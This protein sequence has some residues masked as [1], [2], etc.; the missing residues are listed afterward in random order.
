MLMVM[1]SILMT[2]RYAVVFLALELPPDEVDVNVHPTKCEVRFRDSHALHQL[3]TAELIFRRGTPPDAEYTF[4]HAL[5]QDAAYS[6]LLR[7]R[8]QQLHALITAT[9]EDRFPE[10]VASQ[11][12]LL[13]KHCAEAGLN[14]KAMN[15]WCT[16]GQHAVRRA[17][18]P[19]ARFAHRSVIGAVP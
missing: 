5:V 7:S 15:Y 3:V 9:L 10:I 13:A 18:L 19:S 4:K 6:T 2:G 17:E 8:R 12:A 16:A 1:L 11:P 14:E